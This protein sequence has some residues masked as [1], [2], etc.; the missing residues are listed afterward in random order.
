MHA[1]GVLDRAGMQLSYPAIATPRRRGYGFVSFEDVT[2]AAAAVAAMN[3]RNIGGRNIEA[4]PLALPSS[5]EEQFLSLD[6]HALILDSRRNSSAHN[7]F[8][9]PAGAQAAARTSV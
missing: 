4:R 8:P 1:I 2:G 6:L 7:R 5:S 9:T 3:G